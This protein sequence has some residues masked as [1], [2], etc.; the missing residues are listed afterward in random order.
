MGMVAVQYGWKVLY[1]VLATPLTYAL[2]G[3]LKKHEGEVFD[4]GISYNPFAL[5]LK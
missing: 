3:W 2:V 4:S 5:T 1:E